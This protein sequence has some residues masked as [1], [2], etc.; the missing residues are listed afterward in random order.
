MG[1]TTSIRC[2]PTVRAA[3]LRAE[4]AAA[5]RE[6]LGL[7]FGRPGIERRHR[8]ILQRLARLESELRAA[9]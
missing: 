9:Q 1:V 2:V 6:L 5:R 4:I 7:R 8:E 3:E